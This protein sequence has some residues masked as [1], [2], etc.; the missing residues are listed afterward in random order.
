MP[1]PGSVGT[2]TETSTSGPYCAALRQAVQVVTTEQASWLEVTLW[3][4][5]PGM[6]EFVQ[7][8]PSV[9]GFSLGRLKEST[10]VSGE[11]GGTAAS[12]VA[13]TSF[14]SGPLPSAFEANT[15]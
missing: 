15:L 1:S 12:G 14:E 10:I 9:R 6:T 13:E 5:S 2:R 11:A 8:A 3:P 7:R 4:L